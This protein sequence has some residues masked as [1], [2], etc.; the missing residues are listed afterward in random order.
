L[1]QQDWIL[2]VTQ[3]DEMTGGAADRR[4]NQPSRTGGASIG[5]IVLTGGRW[6]RKTT[7]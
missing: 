5:Y 6:P 4:G 3:L 7:G 1:K 2:D